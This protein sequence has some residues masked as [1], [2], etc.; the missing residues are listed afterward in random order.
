[1]VLHVLQEEVHLP[2]SGMKDIPKYKLL[3]IFLFLPTFHLIQA[4]HSPIRKMMNQQLLYVV[5]KIK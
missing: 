3:L 4:Y 2:Y 5:L 1:M